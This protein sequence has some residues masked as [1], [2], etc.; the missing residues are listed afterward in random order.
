MRS[1]REAFGTP[2]QYLA[3]HRD[4]VVA[5][6]ALEDHELAGTSSLPCT[7]RALIGGTAQRSPGFST[8]FA[9]GARISTT[10]GPSRQTKL[11]VIAEW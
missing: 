9:R 1:V 7:Q 3:A 5:A 8:W 2:A 4:I 6:D 10:I 11:S